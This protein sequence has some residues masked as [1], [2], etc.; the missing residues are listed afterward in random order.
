MKK[1]ELQSNL[2]KRDEVGFKSKCLLNWSKITKFK[3]E[4]TESIE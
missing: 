4:T 2:E 1:L 3:E